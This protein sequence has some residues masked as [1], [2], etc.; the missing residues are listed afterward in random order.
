M[1]D[2]VDRL[3]VVNDRDEIGIDRDVVIPD[4]VTER[5]KVPDAFAGL[6]VERDG[7]VGEEIVAEPV[8]AVKVKRRRAETGE[9]QSALH[10]NTQATPGIGPASVFPG[11]VAFPG[12][13]SELAGLGNSVKAPDLF[14]GSDVECANVARRG[15]R[16]PLVARD[17]DDDRVLPDRHGGG[18]AVIHSRDF[19]IEF[20]AEVA[21]AAVA[22]LGVELSGRGVEREQPAVG[23][24][25]NDPSL[26]SRLAVGPV[27]AAAIDTA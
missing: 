25:M 13:V 6:G 4:V 16:R 15:D 27:R 12:F 3:A 18:R 14:T 10:V 2:G 8:A 20:L 24:S 22:E 17:A 7:A 23:N 19:G 1:S 21:N 26:A 11:G 5:L 9:N